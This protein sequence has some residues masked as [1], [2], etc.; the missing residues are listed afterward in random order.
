MRPTLGYT[1][2]PAGSCSVRDEVLGVYD[3]SGV[4]TATAK[5]NLLSAGTI[6]VVTATPNEAVDGMSANF[7]IDQEH[8]AHIIG[9]S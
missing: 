6:C 5:V 2:S 7:T 8:I 3:G 4:A 1:T 9:G